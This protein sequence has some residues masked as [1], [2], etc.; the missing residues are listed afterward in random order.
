[1]TRARLNCI[2]F[3]AIAFGTSS[4]L[5][6]SGS[7][8]MYAGPLNDCA[9]P[10]RN[11]S[12]KMCQT[13]TVR[14]QIRKPSTRAKLICRYCDSSMILRRSTRSAITPPKSENR[15]I[16]PVARNPSTPSRNAEFVMF[17]TTHPCATVCI[18]VPTVEVKAP[19][20]SSR[21]SR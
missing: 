12:R 4:R 7:S 5:T 6:S 9:L 20:Q 2:E 17:R 13:C 15:S 10:V 8:E 1:M 18:H 19:I 14:V 21:K 3:M 16:G 11:D